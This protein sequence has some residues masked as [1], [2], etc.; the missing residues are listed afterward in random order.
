MKSKKKSVSSGLPDDKTMNYINSIINKTNSKI[1]KLMKAVEELS[2]LNRSVNNDSSN[3]LPSGSIPKRPRESD[4]FE[5]KSNVK[6]MLNCDDHEYTSEDDEDA[7]E[8]MEASNMDNTDKTRSSEY[9]IGGRFNLFDRDNNEDFLEPN[10]NE[11]TKIKAIKPPPIIIKD[12]ER[13][14]GKI[15]NIKAITNNYAGTLLRITTNNATIYPKDLDQ[16]KQLCEK[17]KETNLQFYTYNPKQ[18]RPKVMLLRGIHQE[19]STDEI[20]KELIEKG[21]KAISVYQMR[22]FIK[23][24]EGNERQVNLPCFTVSFENST[25]NNEIFGIIGC[26]GYKVN[27]EMKRKQEVTQCRKCQ[28][29]GHVASCCNMEY[30]CVKCAKPHP[31]GDCPRNLDKK[32][33]L[34]CKNCGDEHVASYPGCPERQLFMSKLNKP[35]TT[36]TNPTKVPN[37]FNSN[38]RMDNTSYAETIREKS[39]EPNYLSNQEGSHSNSSS[40]HVLNDFFSLS[41]KF[42]GMDFASL[43]KQVSLFMTNLKNVQDLVMQKT[44]YLN[45]ICQFI[46]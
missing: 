32:V 18:H 19:T 7:V 14:N 3:N 16:H 40:N 12:Y 8:F 26:C 11:P 24:N 33:P 43:T 39:K 20:K 41:Q 31:P 10:N 37:L 28:T 23:D 13:Q 27:W 38:Y 5:I 9:P 1:S 45:F 30:H 15:I 22:K 4:S 6:K 29:F 17:L 35:F 2:K 46:K 25:K 21:L 42:F 34:K 44:M 36:K